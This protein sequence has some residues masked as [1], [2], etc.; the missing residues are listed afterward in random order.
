M[1]KYKCKKLQ[2]GY[3]EY[4]G[5]EINSFQSN[6]GGG[7]TIA[8]NIHNLEGDWIN[9]VNTKWQAKDLIDYYHNEVKKWVNYIQHI[10]S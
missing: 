5:Y 1:N 3:Y 2:A 9:T 6:F 10:T 8:W 7:N 4:R